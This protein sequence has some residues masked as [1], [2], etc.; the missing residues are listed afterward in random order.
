[1]TEENG[2]SIFNIRAYLKV[3][4]TQLMVCKENKIHISYNKTTG[5]L[6]FHFR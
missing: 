6:L 4:L 1:M 5:N 3:I 2:T